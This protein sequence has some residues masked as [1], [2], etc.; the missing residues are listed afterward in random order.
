MRIFSIRSE[1]QRKEAGVLGILTVWPL[2][3]VVYSTFTQETPQNL[4]LCAGEKIY[5]AARPKVNC[6]ID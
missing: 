6:H 4:L 5:V 2:Q 1:M 3:L